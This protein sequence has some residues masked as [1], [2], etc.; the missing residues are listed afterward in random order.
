MTTKY[1]TAQVCL[2]GRMITS[3]FEREG[4]SNRCEDCGAPTITRCPKC[5]SQIRGSIYGSGIDIGTYPPPKFCNSCGEPYPWTETAIALAQ[6]LA[7]ETMEFNEEERKL[8]IESIPDI[9]SDTQKSKIA[10]PRFKRI[11]GKHGQK[12][13]DEFKDILLEFS[14]RTAAKMLKDGP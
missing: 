6:E 3:E 8:I 11:V 4:G 1:F 12:I 10:I 9:V 5:D 2:N 7:A 13:W 14:S